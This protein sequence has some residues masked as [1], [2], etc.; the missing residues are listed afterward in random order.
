MRTATLGTIVKAG[1][2]LDLFTQDRPEWGNAEISAALRIPKATAHAVLNS[3]TKINLLVRT[4]DSRYRLSWR[5]LE[6]SEAV[7]VSSRDIHTAATG[8]LLRLS[9]NLQRSVFLAAM[10]GEYVALI[11]RLL[12]PNAATEAKLNRRILPAHA[13]AA[14]K[15]LLAYSPP[16][17]VERILRRGMVKFTET[18]IVSATV[19]AEELAVVRKKGYATSLEENIRGLCCLAAPI[20]DIDRRAVAA[21]TI[22]TDR[23]DLVTNERHLVRSVRAAA[24]EASENLGWRPSIGAKFP[25]GMSERL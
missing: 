16:E 2:V 18:T 25:F 20:M 8:V 6:L 22:S 14:G 3:L 7:L 12:G 1:R 15:A 19:F 10:D 13:T 17:L 11:E 21:V 4:E 23:S 24:L 5:V 9:K